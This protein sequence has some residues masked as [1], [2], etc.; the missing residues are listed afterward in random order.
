MSELTTR[1]LKNPF[2]RYLQMKLFGRNK[3]VLALV[4]LI[5]VF[6]V[7][8]WIIWTRV[9]L[10]SGFVVGETTRLLFDTRFFPSFLILPFVNSLISFLNLLLAFLVYRKNNLSSF[11][12]MSTTIFINCSVL[13]TIIFYIF[14]FIL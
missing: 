11:I 7:V 14:S 2:Y 8:I 13:A 12:L 1:V 4:I 10:P 3:N 5:I 9:L 6:N